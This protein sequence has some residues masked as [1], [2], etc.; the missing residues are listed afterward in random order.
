MAV[1]ARIGLQKSGIENRGC[2]TALIRQPSI[3]SRDRFRT[4]NAGLFMPGVSY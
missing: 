4:Q 2:N 3:K 1:G